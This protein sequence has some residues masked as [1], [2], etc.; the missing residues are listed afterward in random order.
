M[1]YQTF[2]PHPHLE[3]LI[4]CY[5]TLEVPIQPAATRQ[6]I[7]PDGCIE[8]IFILGDD[9]KRYTSEEAYILQPRTMVLGQISEPFFVEPTGVVHSFAIRF[10][11]YGFANFTS[12]PIKALANR[13]T[14]LGLLLGEKIAGD[15]EHGIVHAVNTAERIAIMDDFFLHKLKEHMI[16]DNILKS[17]VDMM[18]SAKGNITTSSL[19]KGE[20][21]KRRQLERKFFKQV[22][23]SPKQLGKVIRLQAA[24][25]MLLNRKSENL[26]SIAYESQYY[27][28]AHFIKDFK[29]FTGVSPKEFYK[30]DELALS[31]LIYGKD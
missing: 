3:A 7:L 29:E 5:W 15:L 14:P 18:L 22:G 1:N 28:Q 17:T 30:D 13:E 23:M 9:V 31:S 26:T 20:L 11:P 12:I 6:R 19:L 2:Q 27:D 16:V 21:S 8:M 4:K 24:L 25:K 10:Y